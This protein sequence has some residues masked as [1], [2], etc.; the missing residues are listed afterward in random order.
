VTSRLR[1]HGVSVR[2]GGRRVLDG[3]DIEVPPGAWV[4]V[5]GPNGAGKSTLVRALAG[6]V[7]REG[8]VT[9][10]DQTL[11]AIGRRAWARLLAVVPQT[12]VIPAGASVHDYVLLGRTPHLGPLG[13][14][15]AGDLAVVHRVLSELDLVEMAHRPL[16][17]LSGGERQRAVI[18]RALAQEAPVLVLDE[19]TTA[20]DIGH[21][22]EV[23]ELVDRLRRERGL[24]VLATMHDLTLAGRY[25]ERLVLLD[26]GR[27]VAEGAPAQVLTE[28]VVARFYRAR[29]RLLADDDGSVVVI[30]L[31]GGGQA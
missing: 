11:G 29:V 18:G 8:T 25:S 13:R 3:V 26:A 22:Q 30:P 28:E 10:D 16:A 31:R 15:G 6:T 27:V 24:A 20:L 23:L 17:S 1:A 21:Q 7:D 4:S 14:E 12:P 19:P 9:I 2:L 5:I